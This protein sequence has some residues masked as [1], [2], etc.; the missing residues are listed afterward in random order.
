MKDPFDDA[1]ARCTSL[2]NHWCCMLN[3]FCSLIANRTSFNSYF[4]EQQSSRA[5]EQAGQLIQSV[6]GGPRPHLEVL[7]IN[8][9]SAGHTPK[10]TDTQTYSKY[11]AQMGARADWPNHIIFLVA[12]LAHI[13]THAS[14]VP[15]FTL[16]ILVCILQRVLCL[17]CFLRLWKN[18]NVS[19]KTC[20]R[21]S[22]LVLNGQMRVPK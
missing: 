14:I 4:T 5:A 1:W 15:D 12:F 2:G 3:C 19:R 22:D 6:K 8:I 17:C 13:L 11:F 16:V 7:S 20:K 9:K 18:N 21:R 10:N